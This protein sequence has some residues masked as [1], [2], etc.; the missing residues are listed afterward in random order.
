MRSSARNFLIGLLGLLAVATA[1][2][3]WIAFSARDATEQEPSAA[4]DAGLGGPVTRSVEYTVDSRLLERLAVYPAEVKLTPP[5][6][7]SVPALGIVTDIWV[8]DGETAALGDPII[9]VD[10]SP[11]FAMPM[12][13]DLYRD[14]EPDSS[15]RDVE[16]LQKALNAVLG[17]EVTVDG[18][19]GP[20]TQKAVVELFERHGMAPERILAEDVGVPDLA[21]QV[22][23]VDRRLKAAREQDPRDP[24]AEAELTSELSR[25]RKA[26]SKARSLSGP[27]LRAANV[28][29]VEAALPVHRLLVAVGDRVEASPVAETSGGVFAA[30]MDVPTADIRLLERGMTVH[31]RNRSDLTFTVS[32]IEPHPE[33]HEEARITLVPSESTTLAET[34]FFNVEFVA[35]TTE[36]PVIAVPVGLIFLDVGGEASVLVRDG[37]EIV[38]VGVQTGL[39]IDGLAEILEPSGIAAGTVLV[40]G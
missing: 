13:F 32:E 5:S 36:T 37:D 26:L 31:G 40:G 4:D 19:Y 1:V 17:A 15:G 28:V 30:T 22:E 21:A 23:S 11:V 33:R 12:G 39:V 38:T 10:G 6:T 27:L 24:E 25:A 3:L 29:A 9:G 14:I 2:N 16:E 20:Q 8:A 34:D 18:Q 7:L 35:E